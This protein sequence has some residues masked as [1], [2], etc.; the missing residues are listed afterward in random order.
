MTWRVRILPDAAMDGIAVQVARP[1]PGS[2]VVEVLTWQQSSVTVEPAV[3]PAG[4]ASLKVDDGLGRA[5]LD[6]LAAHYGG[7]TGGR[8]QRADF[9][10]ER[11]RVDRLLDTLT[12]I[13][14]RGA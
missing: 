10:H 4:E 12:I 14:T 6:A 1:L 8:Q 3:H 2:G 7:T 13:A 9:E 5:L 11:G